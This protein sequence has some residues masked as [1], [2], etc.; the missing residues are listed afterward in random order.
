MESIPRNGSGSGKHRGGALA[1][2]L[3]VHLQE[4]R[5]ERQAQGLAFRP[6][7]V[8]VHAGPGLGRVRVY[9][10]SARI[11]ASG[12]VEF[13]PDVPFDSLG[14]ENGDERVSRVS[15]PAGVVCS[16]EWLRDE[17]LAEASC[18]EEACD[19]W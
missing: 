17:D 9:A 2:R 13:C 19:A 1:E 3:L 10:G 7:R 15:F 16:V 4:E 18:L 14:G 6:A 11:A 12:W 8:T 5:R